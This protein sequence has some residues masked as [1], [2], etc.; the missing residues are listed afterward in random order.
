MRGD[1][2]AHGAGAENNCFLDRMSHEQTLRSGI[3]T[4]EQVTKWDATGQTGVWQWAGA[5]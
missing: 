2:G 1:A 3:R 5:A 4:A